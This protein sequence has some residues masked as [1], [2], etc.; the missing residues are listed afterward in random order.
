M[1]DMMIPTIK[2]DAAEFLDSDE[3][4]SAY[5]EAA[6]EDGDEALIA[7]ARENIARARERLS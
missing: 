3:E 6:L 5:L 1:A 4:I 7:S 2:W